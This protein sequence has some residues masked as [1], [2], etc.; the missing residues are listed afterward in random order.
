MDSET[1]QRER[2]KEC[3]RREWGRRA[4]MNAIPAMCHALYRH[5]FI[6]TSPKPMEFISKEGHFKKSPFDKAQKS[7][8]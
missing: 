1:S 3:G 4:N 6:K 7:Y 2:G 5:Y 8:N